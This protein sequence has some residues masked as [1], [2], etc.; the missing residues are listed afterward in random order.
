MVPR[1]KLL[2]RV[3]FGVG[4][5][6][7]LFIWSRLLVFHPVD[8]PKAPGPIVP[9]FTATREGAQ[10]L[11]QIAPEQQHH[12]SAVTLS[13]LSKLSNNNNKEERQALLVESLKRIRQ[14][15]LE[16]LKDP[17]H[18]ELRF[19]SNP[20]DGR[21]PFSTLVDGYGNITADISDLLQFAIVGFGKC[22]STT[23]RDW[24]NTHPRIQCFYPDEVLDLVQHDLRQLLSRLYSMPTGV[25]VLRGFKSPLDL[26]LRHVMQFYAKYFYKTKLIVGMRHP[27]HW[28]QSLC[29]YIV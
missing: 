5:C 9:S 25:D 14:K 7:Y 19:K 6:L 4:I 11:L 13:E 26:S 29:T 8:V 17:N 16:R 12:N 3:I 15:A 27:V 2:L 28:F 1:Q 22:A 24:L 21:P 23:M 18:M 20:G 10:V